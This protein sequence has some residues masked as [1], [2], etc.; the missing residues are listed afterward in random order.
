MEADSLDLRQRVLAAVDAGGHPRTELA[1]L[2][3]VSVAWIRRLVQRRRETGSI[4][5]QP[6]RYGPH[7]KLDG[8]HRQR[9][10]KLVAEDACATLVELRQRLQADV[11]S[12]TIGRALQ[13]LGLTRKKSRRGPARRT[14]PT[15]RRSGRPSGSGWR[16]WSPRASSSSTS[17]GPRPR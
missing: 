17:R 7:P 3:R 12:S 4:A 1:A 8:A 14:G 2:F 11:S 13:Q 16:G 15:C 9:L 5:P 10:A 6:R